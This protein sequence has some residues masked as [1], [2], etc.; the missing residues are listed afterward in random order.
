MGDFNPHQP[1]ILGN[2]FVPIREE[3]MSFSP[4]VNAVEYGTGFTTRGSTVPTEAR[5]FTNDWVSQPL[6]TTS[7]DNQTINVTIYPAG[8]EGLSGPVRRLVIPCNGWGVTGT[9]GAASLTGASVAQAMMSP[10]DTNAVSWSL[11]TNTGSVGMLFNYNNNSLAVAARRILGVNLLYSARYNQSSTAF[12][13]PGF[14][15]QI[16]SM[17]NSS[18]VFR[19]RYSE[20]TRF[21][22]NANTVEDYPIYRVRLGEIN[23]FFGGT[24]T[25]GVLFPW[26]TAQLSRFDGGNVNPLLVVLTGA[27]P[28]ASTSFVLDYCALE[29]IYCEEQRLFV[30]TCL[31]NNNNYG[32]VTAQMRDLP[33]GGTGTSLAAGNYTIAVSAP[34]RGDGGGTGSLPVPFTPKGP[35]INALRELY[36][37]PPHLGVAINHPFPVDDSI[38]DQTFTV[39]ATPIHGQVA[40]YSATGVVSE[41]FPYGKQAVAQ[42]YGNVNQQARQVIQD[43]NY[44]VAP[45][46]AAS[47]PYV[48][49]YA[50][51]WGDT[52]VPLKVSSS[53]ATIS[54]SPYSVYLTPPEFDALEPEDGIID[55]WKEVTLQF[56][57][58]PVMGTGFNPQWVFSASGE[59]D[60]NRWEILGAYAP[61]ISGAP[62][63]LL[64]P[65]LPNSTT[66]LAPA[67]YGSPPDVSG[68]PVCL[69]WVPQ[70]NPPTVAA[71]PDVTADAT[72]LFSQYPPAITGLGITMLAQS[73]TG[74]GSE[75]GD[76]NCCIPTAILYNKAQW[77]IPLPIICDK[78]DRITSNGWGTYLGGI[79]WAVTG[80]AANWSTNGSQ[81]LFVDTTGVEQFMVL[82][83]LGT[84]MVDYDVTVQI[85]VNNS[86]ENAPVGILA[87]YQSGQDYV[88]HAVG[89]NENTS[90][91]NTDPLSSVYIRSRV[92]SVNSTLDSGTLP[93]R[94]ATG[95]TI[96]IRAQG[97]IN[98][99]RTKVWKYGEDEPELWNLDGSSSAASQTGSVGIY[100]ANN[101]TY[102]F[103]NFLAVPFGL[104]G[105]S[106]ELQRMD[107][108]NSWQTIMRASNLCTS[109]FN[110]YEARVG[111]QSS[112]R[113]RTLNCYEFEGQWSSTALGTIQSPG[114]SGGPCLN[115]SGVL[116]FTSNF[117]QTGLNNLAYVEAYEGRPEQ[118]FGFPE[119]NTL[120]L[121]RMY[122][123]NFQVAFKGTE[124]GGEAFTRQI[125]VQAAA[126]A[127]PRL[128]DMHSLRDMAWADL[129]YVAVRDDI[130][131]RW[132][133][134]V[135]VP[136]NKVWKRKIY[137]A[138]IGIVEVSD[139]PYPVDP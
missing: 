6:P 43:Y 129:P 132:L 98:Q 74:I 99:F 117:D 83:N 68:G 94:I 96:Y 110:D 10:G 56:P 13:D 92:A 38:V 112:Y 49:F 101:G 16:Q 39:E 109:S 47:Y 118:T 12:T 9:G 87:R 97:H 4:I 45:M 84:S 59:A 79:N 85:T 120:Q 105:S 30:G 7:V 40:L 89:V 19:Y 100:A 135:N 42:V 22:S 41:I 69:S 34:D 88:L 102:S 113:I 35:K 119:A 128:A 52:T 44:R 50:R 11:T 77:S 104:T 60:A 51:R 80:V 33:L 95:D 23:P 125:L 122:R 134:A 15:W 63:T 54:G 131:D 91:V 66:T 62:G 18:V 70:W 20:F 130:G 115:G 55:G 24:P 32:A 31:T 76:Y 138:Q 2:E 106:Y 124:R 28:S 64:S 139:T 61:A 27:L 86:L 46:G 36:S 67:T 127:L 53:A 57:T 103:D 37:L 108:V 81:G 21:D 8:S 111:V 75:C 65:L 29:I 5:F 90:N 14:I 25:G 17:V 133:S 123:R 1:Y 93:L 48:R 137:L 3:T 73:V 121:Q 114:V 126:V 116:I 136:T 72:L 26:T 71:N 107:Q 82:Q 78:Y 58:A